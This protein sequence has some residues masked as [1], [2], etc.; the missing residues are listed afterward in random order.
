M[1]HEMQDY[2]RFVEREAT[3]RFQAG[4]DATA[5]ADDIDLGP[6][7]DW[8]DRERIAVNVDAVYHELDPALAPTPVPELF[9][10]MA[11]WRARH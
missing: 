7:A 9:V 8:N 1:V 2:L 5:A 10:R 6:Y 11:E 4:M 3:L